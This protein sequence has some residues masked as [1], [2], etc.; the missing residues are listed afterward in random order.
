MEDYRTQLKQQLDDS[1]SFD[2]HQDEN[3]NFKVSGLPEGASNYFGTSGIAAGPG[4]DESND[5]DESREM[6][7]R[8]QA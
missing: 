1:D 6:F 3:I 2:S 5:N 4:L 8:L 7:S